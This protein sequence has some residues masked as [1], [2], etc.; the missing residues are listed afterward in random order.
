M[1]NSVLLRFPSE[2]LHH[3]VQANRDA[4]GPFRI[5]RI[6]GRSRQLLCRR[7]LSRGSF[8][9]DLVV[10]LVGIHPP[11]ALP[12]RTWMQCHTDTL[13]F[14]ICVLAGSVFTVHPFGGC[15][16]IDI[17]KLVDRYADWYLYD[18]VFRLCNAWHSC[19]FTRD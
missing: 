8:S 15:I 17:P 2:G 14:V 7:W 18:V 16:D 4:V 9:V 1:I 19:S 5:L 3:G 11:V 10:G 13:L 12:V 6:N